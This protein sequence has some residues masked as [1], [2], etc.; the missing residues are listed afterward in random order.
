M[1]EK[2]CMYTTC[3]VVSSF[4]FYDSKSNR[5]RIIFSHLSKKRINSKLVQRQ[6]FYMPVV[7]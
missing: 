1:L 7:K 2:K 4:F 3:D 6:D 5:N